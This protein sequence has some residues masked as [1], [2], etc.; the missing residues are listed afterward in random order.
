MIYVFGKK[1]VDA[2]DCVV[3]LL[4]SARMLEEGLSSVVLRTDVAYSHAAGA[5]AHG[6][7]QTLLL[8]TL[9]MLYFASFAL[10][11]HRAK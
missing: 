9:Q 1:E 7:I 8:T 3:K 11:S 4:E 5:F 10:H 6:I 2:Q